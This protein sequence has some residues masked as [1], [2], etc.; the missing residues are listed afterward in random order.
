[1][2]RV[3]AGARSRPLDRRNSGQC[4]WG[5]R[6]RWGGRPPCREMAGA[7]GKPERLGGG[8]PQS[9]ARGG[10][11]FGFAGGGGSLS[12][13]ASLGRAKDLDAASD[14]PPPDEIEF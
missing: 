3:G 1:S 10:P 2:P 13:R 5:S 8:P 14:D 4:Q 11:D 12:P 9:G 6:G 7:E